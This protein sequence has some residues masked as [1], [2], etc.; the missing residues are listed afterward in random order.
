[1]H[2]VRPACPIA[3]RSE[4]GRPQVPGLALSARILLSDH[5]RLA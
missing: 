2:K 3:I 4:L 1:M 5:E